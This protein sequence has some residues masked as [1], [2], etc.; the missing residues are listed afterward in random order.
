MLCCQECHDYIFFKPNDYKGMADDLN[1]M[2]IRLHEANFDYPYKINWQDAMEI[3]QE[4]W[5]FEYYCLN[6]VVY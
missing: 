6:Q 1:E 2:R 3:E 4:I 5:N